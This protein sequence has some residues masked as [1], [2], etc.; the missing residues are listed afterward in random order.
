MRGGSCTN[1]RNQ[2]P[3]CDHAENRN[4]KVF[5]VTCNKVCGNTTKS[6]ITLLTV[7]PQNLPRYRK[8][9]IQQISYHKFSLPFTYYSSFCITHIH[10]YMYIYIYLYSRIDST[11]R[12]VFFFSLA[13]FP[14]F[15]LLRHTSTPLCMC[16]YY[17]Y[18]TTLPI[19]FG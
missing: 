8:D 1:T 7:A 9:D 17:A 6:F 11:K 5:F 15:A 12:G 18:Y 3:I 10:I 19:I 14:S 4:P 16:K 2:T 13:T